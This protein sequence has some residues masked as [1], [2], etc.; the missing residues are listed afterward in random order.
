MSWGAIGGAAITTAGSL[1]GGGG[2]GGPPRWLRKANKAA[3]GRAEE[4]SNRPYSSYTGDRVAGLSGNER[5][6]GALARNWGAATQPYFDDLRS[7][8]QFDPSQLSQYENPYLDRVLKAR[9]RVIGDEYGRQLGV[10]T[11]NQSAT[12]AFRTGRS[13]LA[14]SRLDDNRMLAL[15]DAEGEARAG[16]Y[17]SALGAYQSNQQLRYNSDMGALGATLDSQRGQYGALMGSGGVERSIRQGQMDFD[18]GQFLEGR[19]WDVNN[20]GITLDALRTAQGSGA[21]QGQG[22]PSNGSLLAGLLGTVVSNYDWGDGFDA[23]GAE[24]QNNS[25]LNN[26]FGPGS[27]GS[28]GPLEI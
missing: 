27:S 21:E 7:N 23:A 14:R 2:N 1:L 17:Q 11:R 3:V 24:S 5:Q 12:D 15:D 6:A 16:A 18:Y 26:Q 25:Y 9:Q 28:R 4:L 19:D 10:L 20:F 8:A 13:D 22:G